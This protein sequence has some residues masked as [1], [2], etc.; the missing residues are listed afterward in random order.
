MIERLAAAGIEV[1]RV[2]RG[3]DHGVWAGFMAGVYPY[4]RS[5]FANFLQLSIQR[6][7]HWVC[8]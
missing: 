8:Q 3:L 7:T 4:G 6:R 2:E 5:I 1:D